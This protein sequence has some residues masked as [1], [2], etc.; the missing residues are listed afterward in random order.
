MNIVAAILMLIDHIGMIFFPGQVV[1]RI[2]GRVSMPLFAYGVAAGFRYTSSFKNYIKRMLILAIVSQGP[3]LWMYK[4]AFGGGFGLNIGFTF[5]IA[6]GCLWLVQNAEQQ[7]LFNKISHY[8]MVILLL[9]LSEVLHCDYGI[10]GVGVVYVFY[11]YN[12]KRQQSSSAYLLFGLW[13]II[14]SVIYG[15][16][17]QI[18]AVA[19]LVAIERLK[20]YRFK[21]LR[22]FF[23]VFYPLH[24]L[25]L[26][27]IK[28]WLL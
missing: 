14:Y 16:F 24:M 21:A 17:L 12:F 23:Y 4:V 2:L 15:Q 11:Q 7:P 27:M 13:T 8:V 22:Y 6:L 25:L 10:Y 3:F 1:W 19:A 18:Y 5:S 28:V 26:V 9:I 20:D